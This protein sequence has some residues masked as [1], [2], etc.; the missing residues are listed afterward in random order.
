MRVVIG[1]D[2]AGW[3]LKKSVIDHVR[4]LGHEVV[5]VGSFDDK[6]VDFPDIA[7]EV[8]SKVTSGEVERG[9]M[10]CGTGVGAS[11]AAN[12]VK[13][14]RAAVCH[15]VHSAHQ[16]VEHD[17]VNVMCLGAQIVGPWLAQDLVSSYISATFSTDEDCRRRVEKLHALEAEG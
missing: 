9:I 3:V 12:K 11:I 2:H 8:T 16:S 1:S 13:G 6:P 4:S 7:R 15:D 17:D 10:V 5:D 14:I